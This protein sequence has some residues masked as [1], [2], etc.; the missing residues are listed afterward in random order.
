MY[1]HMCVHVNKEL[2]VNLKSVGGE[3]RAGIHLDV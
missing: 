3:K 1:I 2:I